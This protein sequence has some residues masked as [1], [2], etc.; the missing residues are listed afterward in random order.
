MKVNTNV[1]IKFCSSEL[2]QWLVISNDDF[3]RNQALRT[4]SAKGSKSQLPIRLQEKDAPPLSPFFRDKKIV[5][6]RSTDGC[7]ELRFVI[8]Q[9]GLWRRDGTVWKNLAKF[10]IVPDG[11]WWYT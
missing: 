8:L 9:D 1:F 11:G 4:K 10:E 7:V 6:H 5:L 2:A 3:R